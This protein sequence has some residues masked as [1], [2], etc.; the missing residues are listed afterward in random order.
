[1]DTGQRCAPTASLTALYGERVEQALDVELLGAVLERLSLE[2]PAVNTDGLRS[3]Y[4]AW[5]DHVSFDNLQKLV[6]LREERRPLPGDD[7]N[8]FFGNWLR[9]GTGAT[10][11]ASS[12]ALYHLLG[13]LGFDVTRL[14]G[15]MLDMPDPNHATNL[16][17]VDGRRYLVDTS[18]LSGEPV[19]VGSERTEV[20]P[21]G[22]AVNLTPD[23]ETWVMTFPSSLGEAMICRVFPAGSD[24]ETY[25][26][27]HEFTRDFSVFND[28]IHVTRHADGYVWNLRHRTLT[29]LHVG[30]FEQTELSDAER[31]SWLA[32]VGFSERIVEAALASER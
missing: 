8:E 30:E 4:R 11:W 32:G 1:M 5:C 25:Q 7:A 6:A 9:D 28:H 23:G 29:K 20:D 10:C 16:V 17:A 3:V 26:Q 24:A 31:R 22:Y 27:I 2:P 19:E 21:A 15:A 14:T 13:Q 18:V 12:N